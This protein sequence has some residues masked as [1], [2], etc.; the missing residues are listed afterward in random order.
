MVGEHTRVVTQLPTGYPFSMN[1]S[2][3]ALSVCLP[4]LAAAPP[5]VQ[6]PWERHAFDIESG[7]LWQVGDNTTIDY[8]IVQNQFSWR[9]P[10]VFKLDMDGGSTVVVRNHASLIAAW[11]ADGPEDYY[12]GVSGSPSLEWW[13]AD[14]LWSLYFSIGGGAGVTN[15]TN[16]PGGQGQD[17]TLNW[18]AKAGARYQVSDGLAVFGGPFFQHISNGGATTPNPGIDALGFTVGLSLSF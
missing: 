1:R 7:L 9:S 18:F 11:I 17:F 6:A 3:L 13:S 5:D 2:I 8:T 10:Y 16:I 4:T 14:N 15:S 12:L